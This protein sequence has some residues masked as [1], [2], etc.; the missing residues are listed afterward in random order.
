VPHVQRQFIK[1][2]L[3]VHKLLMEAA[4]TNTPLNLMS[5]NYFLFAHL[6]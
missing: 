1:V 6:P 4:L 3:I 5:R 2:T